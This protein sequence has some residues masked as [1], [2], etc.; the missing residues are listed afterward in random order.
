MNWRHHEDKLVRGR[1]PYR[2]AL[3]GR[4]IRQ[5]AQHVRRTGFDD[6]GPVTFRMHRVCESKTL[7]WDEN[8]WE[9]FEPGEFC[10]ETLGLPLWKKGAKP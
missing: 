7:G 10:T 9:C 3:C 6:D 2:C 5:G 8:D 4:R 1:K